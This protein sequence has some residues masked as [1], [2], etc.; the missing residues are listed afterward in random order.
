MSESYTAICDG[1]P[2][3]TDKHPIVYLDLTD[4]DVRRA[5]LI[6]ADI[7]SSIKKYIRT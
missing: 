6:G 7:N 1:G 3:E 4:G 5:L 2:N